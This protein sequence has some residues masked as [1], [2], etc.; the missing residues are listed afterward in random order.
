MPVLCTNVTTGIGRNTTAIDDDT[1]D[2]KPSACQN[3]DKGENK[4]NFTVSTDSKK[5]DDGQHNEEHCNPDLFA[6]VR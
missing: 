5:L 4:L 6:L 3:F 1:K 2:D